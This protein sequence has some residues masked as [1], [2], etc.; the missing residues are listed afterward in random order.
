M[1][2]LI[3]F[4]TSHSPV[5]VIGGQHAGNCLNDCTGQGME[6]CCLATIQLISTKLNQYGY[7]PVIINIQYCITIESGIALFI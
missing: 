7:Y 6:G 1:T 4:S 5:Q 2:S 3:Q